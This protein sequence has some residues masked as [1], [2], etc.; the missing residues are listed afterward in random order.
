MSLIGNLP[1]D[2]KDPW[3]LAQSGYSPDKLYTRSTDG[4]GHSET[5]HVKV[6]PALHAMISEAVENINGLR[7]KG[8]VVRDCLIHGAHRYNEWMKAGINTHPID[9]EVR[10]AELQDIEARHL[11]WNDLIE[12]LDRVLANLMKQGD[13]ET[14]THLLEEH[15]EVDSMSPPF[16]L[17]LGVIIE[18]YRDDLMRLNPPARG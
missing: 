7:N 2:P 8:D 14:V 17:R 12:T 18:N 10:M 11:Y 15:A 16:L 9:T 13:Y 4:N 3:A 5:L 1:V 6:S